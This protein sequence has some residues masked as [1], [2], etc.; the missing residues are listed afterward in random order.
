VKNIKLSQDRFDFLAQYNGG[1]IPSEYRDYILGVFDS[2]IVANSSAMYIGDFPP[3]IDIGVIDRSDS[4]LVLKG[5]IHFQGPEIS[6][7]WLAHLSGAMSFDKIVK[8]HKDGDKLYRKAY[9]ILGYSA[10]EWKEEEYT[11]PIDLILE[12]GLGFEYTYVNHNEVNFDMVCTQE[13]WRIPKDLII[14]IENDVEETAKRIV[15]EFD[16]DGIY[17][18]NWSGIFEISVNFTWCL[19]PE[20]EKNENN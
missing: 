18:C 14:L 16:L 6:K 17:I 19:L 12:H 20:S 4:K 3:T 8:N 2:F 7:N 5:E 10:K 15:A 11:G 13:N 1:T 9:R